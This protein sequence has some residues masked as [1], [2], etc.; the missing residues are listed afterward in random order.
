MKIKSIFIPIY[1]QEIEIHDD[2]AECGYK[3]DAVIKACV[4]WDWENKTDKT[5]IKLAF[6]MAETWGEETVCHECAH[7]VFLVFGRLGIAANPQNH[8]HFCYLL[9]WLFVEVI[10]I[11][12]NHEKKIEKYKRK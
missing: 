7:I 12:A 4:K 3:K 9:E 5:P 1:G 11:M 10:N 2:T 6:N 8:E